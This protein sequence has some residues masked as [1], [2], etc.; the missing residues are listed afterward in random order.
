MHI[1]H[2]AKIEALI[3]RRVQGRLASDAAYLNAANAEE[4]SAR[5]HRV[6]LQVE[7]RVLVELLT[8]GSLSSDRIAEL[9]DRIEQIDDEL[10]ELLAADLSIEDVALDATYRDLPPSGS[11]KGV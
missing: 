5:E 10:H 1:S 8:G 2:E 6:T 9:D 7:R 4:Q 3:D 11:T